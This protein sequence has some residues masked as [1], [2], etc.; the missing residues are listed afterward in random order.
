[1]EALEN[2]IGRLDGDDE[3][4]VERFMNEEAFRVALLKLVSEFEYEMIYTYIEFFTRCISRVSQKYAYV[5][6]DKC[7]DCLKIL[8]D[9]LINYEYKKMSSKLFKIIVEELD[10]VL[11]NAN[12]CE[13][14]GIRY[15]TGH[16]CKAT[17]T[18]FNSI[19]KIPKEMINQLK[20]YSEQNQLSRLN[21]FMCNL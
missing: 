1:M 21:L 2:I 20:N 8:F 4:L 18:W 15:P 17:E 13:S 6:F 14:T 9:V 11:R 12:T 10:K 5:D 7:N 3:E 19:D 16:S